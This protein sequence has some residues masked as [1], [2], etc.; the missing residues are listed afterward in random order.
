MSRRNPALI[1]SGMQPA[2]SL[3][4]ALGA[5]ALLV[6]RQ[7]VQVASAVGGQPTGLTLPSPAMLDPEVRDAEIAGFEKYLRQVIRKAEEKFENGGAE[8]L[9]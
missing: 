5:G 6:S 1:C 7:R 3:P 2:Q 9:Q 8:L 4:R